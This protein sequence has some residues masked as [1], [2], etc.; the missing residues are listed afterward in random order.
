MIDTIIGVFG[1]ALN[2]L[3]NALG[4]YAFAILIA[5]LVSQVIVFPVSLLS[6]K[7]RRIKKEMQPKLTAI[8]SKY[9]YTALGLEADND[10]TAF[11]SEDIKAMTPEERVDN[12]R[13]EIK[14]L[15]K[16]HHYHGIISVLPI[17]LNFVFAVLLYGSVGSGCPTPSS[18]AMRLAD[19]LSAKDIK[20][21]LMLAAVAIVPL[22]LSTYGTVKDIISEREKGTKA[23]RPVIASR[24][25]SI[26]TSLAISVW[27]AYSVTAAI[28]FGIVCF[29]IFA[30][31]VAKIIN[32]K[33]DKIVAQNKVESDEN[34][35][36]PQNND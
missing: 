26:V 29:E 32:S 18:Y 31:I 9:H 5:V 8:K 25:I 35:I 20:A 19:A 36:I 30:S 3:G 27:I 4:E 13:R 21:L 16:E 22:I 6:L 1:P 2:A 7:Q 10:S 33:W 12:M 34:I 24:I 15:K 11:M 28:G 23:E 17:L 14:A